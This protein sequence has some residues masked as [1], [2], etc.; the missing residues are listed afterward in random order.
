MILQD[1]PTRRKFR[2]YLKTLKMEENVRFWDATM[3][4]KA[5]PNEN[6][7]YAGAKALI[8]TFVMDNSPLQINLS[9]AIK[10]ELLEAFHKDNK[11]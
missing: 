4:T 7:R 10:Q 1:D 3:L 11:E 6:K 8:Q 9:S 2:R 5:E